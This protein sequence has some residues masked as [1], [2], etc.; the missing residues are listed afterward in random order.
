ML[1]LTFIVTGASF[2]AKPCFH[3]STMAIS[4]LDYELPY[5]THNVYDVTFFTDTI[6]T[7]VTH[8][9]P[10][11][12]QWLSETNPNHRPI[13]VGLDVEWRP[14]F[15]RH[16]Q[17]PVAVLQLCVSRRCLIYQILHSPH[18]PQSLIDWLRDANHMCVGVGIESDVEKLLEDYGLSVASAM[19]VREAAAEHMGVTELR[20][21]GLRELAR[22]VLGKDVVKPKRVTMSRWDSE[23]L[24]PQQVQYACLDAFLSYE[25]GRTVIPGGGAR[26]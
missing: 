1:S 12:D 26:V 14:N 10:L 4:I 25:I 15:N 13:L 20:N 8:S 23:W 9:P 19:D 3:K 21:A 17:N 2:S 5:D 22:E 24:I 11:V 6:H 16:F 7:L 18:I